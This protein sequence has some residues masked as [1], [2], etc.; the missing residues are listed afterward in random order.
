MK[1]VDEVVNVVRF[2]EDSFWLSGGS[3][4]TVCSYDLFSLLIRP[5]I[6]SD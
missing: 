3:L 6:L 2:G 5:P 1:V 4:F